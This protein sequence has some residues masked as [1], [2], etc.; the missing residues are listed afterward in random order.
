MS[1]EKEQAKTGP[2]S[3]IQTTEGCRDVINEKKLL[4]K[5]DL[6]LL[7][8]VTF[9]FLLSFMDRNNGMPSPSLSFIRLPLIAF[10]LETLVSRVSLQTHT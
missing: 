6:N 3:P 1:E 2:T 7:P 4:R 10:Q 9:L 8:G 5:L